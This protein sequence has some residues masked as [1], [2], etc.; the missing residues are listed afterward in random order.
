MADV[1]AKVIKRQTDLVEQEY[2]QKKDRLVRQLELLHRYYDAKRRRTKETLERASV[3]VM[4]K[5]AR[6]MTTLE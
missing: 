2:L 5:W 3:E 4:E 6:L 1:F